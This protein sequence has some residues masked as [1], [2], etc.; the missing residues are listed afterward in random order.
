M[1][2]KVDKNTIRKEDDQPISLMCI[3]VTILRGKKKTET[4]SK[5]SKP[6]LWLPKWKHWGRDK[7]GGCIYTLLYAKSISTISIV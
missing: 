3:Y 5:T 1:I 4:D 2:P 6:N 7:F